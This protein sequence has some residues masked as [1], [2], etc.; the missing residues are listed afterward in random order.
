M[1]TQ[2]R[3]YMENIFVYYMQR[4][5]ATVRV[6]FIMIVVMMTWLNGLISIVGFVK[7]GFRFSC[8]QS[9]SSDLDL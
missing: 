2:K 8:L 3:I 4:S 6:T 5:S 7:Y 9:H 1:M